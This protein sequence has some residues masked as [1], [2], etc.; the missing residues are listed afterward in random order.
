MIALDSDEEN[1]DFQRDP[2]FPCDVDDSLISTSTIEFTNS[3][4]S[5][6]PHK[7]DKGIH[8]WLMRLS[9]EERQLIMTDT[10]PEFTHLLAD[11]LKSHENNRGKCLFSANPIPGKKFLDASQIKTYQLEHSTDIYKTKG[12]ISAASSV[13]VYEALLFSEV[14][15]FT[16]DAPL[17]SISI[18]HKLVEDVQFMLDIFRYISKDQ[19]FQPQNLVQEKAAFLKNISRRKSNYKYSV[20]QDFPLWFSTKVGY[21]IYQWLV[22]YFEHL[23]CKW[24]FTMNTEG[25]PLLL[26]KYLQPARSVFLEHENVC[27]FLTN[28]IDK[29]PI[30]CH[31]Y[32]SITNMNEKPN[33]LL[34][35]KSLENKEEIIRYKNFILYAI[36]RANPQKFIDSLYFTPL[37]LQCIF[38]L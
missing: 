10:C 16:K 11:M 31:I 8:K 15:L 32:N 28:L 18:G 33:D 34:I 14:R 36:S 7:V 25:E 22:A 30:L 23:V 5:I 1:Y 17:D 26:E 38:S 9:T 20:F 24:Y 37:N 12:F 3:M 6:K 4:K 13:P 21:T 35:I 19:C 27:K 2:Y 29:K